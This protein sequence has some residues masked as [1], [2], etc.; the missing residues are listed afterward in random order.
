MRALFIL[1]ALLAITAC[2]V[3][4]PSSSER[5]AGSKPATPPAAR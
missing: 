3:R 4:Q 1:V 2:A 5:R